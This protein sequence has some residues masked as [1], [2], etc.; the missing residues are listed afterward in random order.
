[1]YINLNFCTQNK[2]KKTINWDIIIYNIKAKK[3]MN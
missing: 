2:Q 3:I 1:M